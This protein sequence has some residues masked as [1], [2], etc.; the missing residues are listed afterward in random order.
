MNPQQY[1]YH[2][3]NTSEFHFLTTS[4]RTVFMGKVSVQKIQLSMHGH[5]FIF[6][7][8]NCM[9]PSLLERYWSLF[10]IH[11][12]L[13]CVYPFESL[14]LSLFQNFEKTRKSSFFSELKFRNLDEI[15]KSL[16][17]KNPKFPFSEK[18][19]FNRKPLNFLECHLLKSCS[20]VFF[21]SAR[22]PAPMVGI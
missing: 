18:N 2:S 17:T 10:L 8:Q 3:C 1:S 11:P 22:S 6:F 19:T 15:A 4:F 21:V 12:K 16:R 20:P 14:K 7:Y 13:V 9:N 5:I